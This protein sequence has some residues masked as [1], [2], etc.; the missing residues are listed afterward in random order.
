MTE[1]SALI[2]DDD[3]GDRALLRRFLAKSDYAVRVTEAATVEEALGVQDPDI[4][5]IF[6]DNVLPGETG[7]ES[8]SHF[9]QIWPKAGIFFMTGQG[10]EELAKS[11]IQ[12]GATDYAPKSTLSQNAISRMLKNGV[13]QAL[14]EWR[15]DE[16]RRDLATFTEVLVHDFQAP[17]RAAAYLSE[18]IEEDIEDGDMAEAM[19]GLR[20]LRKSAGQMQDMLRSLSDHVRLDRDDAEAEAC[21]GDLLDRALTALGREIEDSGAVVQVSL[22]DPAHRIICRPPQIAQVLQNLVANA[23]KYSGDAPPDIRIAAFV[24]DAAHLVMTVSDKGLGVPEEYR[25]GIFEPFKRVPGHNGVSGTGL[26]LA[27]CRKLIA[28][29]GGTIWCTSDPKARTVIG[30]RI[31]DRSRPV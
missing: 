8:V 18:Q 25:S 4:R 1:I 9:R 6:L 19:E 11:A 28:R 7:L 22:E 14:A 29:H 30:F 3:D 13:A 2:V 15:L 17:I 21:V 27:T 20:M 5:A 26:G 16:Q 24:D 23:I 10:D 31:P 12:F